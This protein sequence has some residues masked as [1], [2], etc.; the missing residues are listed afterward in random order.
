MSETIVKYKEMTPEENERWQ[1][2]YEEI[3]RHDEASALK[4]AWREGYAEGYAQGLKQSVAEKLK[5][6]GWSE[7]E[8]IDLLGES[9]TG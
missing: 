7:E 1:K 9:Y 5:N 6:K 3:R 2:F 8:I 4:G